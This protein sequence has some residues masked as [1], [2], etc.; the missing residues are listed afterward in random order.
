MH[1]PL[2]PPPSDIQCL[3][4]QFPI[5]RQDRAIVD[6]AQKLWAKKSSSSRSA[7]ESWTPIVVPLRTERCVYLHLRVPAVGGEPVY[8]FERT[9][10]KLVEA[11]DDVE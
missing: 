3:S 8:C 4:T 5:T 7:M 2:P 9:S 6:M 10:G 11:N 1:V